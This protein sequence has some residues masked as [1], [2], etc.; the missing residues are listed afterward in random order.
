MGKLGAEQL[1][2]LKDDLSGRS[3]QHADCLV[4]PHSVVER[5]SRL[6]MGDRGQRAG[7]GAAEAFR[8]GNGAERA[9]PP[10]DAEGRG[11]VRFHTAMS[12][13]FPQ[14]APGNAPSGRADEGPAEKL[15]GVL[16]ISQVEFV[17]GPQHLAV[18]DATLE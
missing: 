17:A 11:Q 12:T 6:G 1:A 14:P 4:R 7:A 13:A 16:G 8:L 18:V 15:R 10:D 5:L 3:G 9:H 2:W